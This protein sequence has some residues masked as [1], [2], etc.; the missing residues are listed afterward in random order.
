[1]TLPCQP[2]RLAAVLALL[3]AAAA[4]APARAQLPMPPVADQIVL[5]L[6]AEQW[7]ETAT[8]EVTVSIEAALGGADAARTRSAMRD[9][10]VSLAPE[11]DWR[12]L[13]FD[14]SVD[15]SG[16]ERWSA[17][18]RARLP[19]DAL[20]GLVDRAAAES[21]PGLQLELAGIDF[22]PTLAEIEAARGE[23]R[24]RLYRQAE[25]ELE[26][27]AEVFPDRG[28]RLARVEFGAGAPPQPVPRAFRADA[29]EAASAAPAPVA[30]SRQLRLEA[31]V[32]LSEL[33]PPPR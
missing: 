7:V 27:L 18:A 12:F 30:V 15:A 29:A 3:L 9:A 24:T 21:V 16:L 32:I 11:A 2:S 8:A 19:E 31:R 1:M 23:L 33:V 10:L 5:Q 4:P 26:R 20:D 22:T 6:A 25:A 28:F 13:R 17:A 14:R